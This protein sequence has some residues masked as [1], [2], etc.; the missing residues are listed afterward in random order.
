MYEVTEQQRKFYKQVGF[1]IIVVCL[2]IAFLAGMMFEGL[3]HECK[4]KTEQAH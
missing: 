4:T 3:T 1:M 2:G